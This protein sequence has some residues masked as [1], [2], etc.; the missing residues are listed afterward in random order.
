MQKTMERI[1]GMS[2]AE[3]VTAFKAC[4]GSSKYAAVSRRLSPA[5]SLRPE[6]GLSRKL[7]N[8]GRCV[9][10]RCLS[11]T[12]CAPASPR[13][14][15]MAAA[16]PFSSPGDLKAK[17]DKVWATCGR[18]AS[19]YLRARAHTFLPHISAQHRWASWRN[20]AHNCKITRA[21][22]VTNERR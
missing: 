9:R 1:N 2:H 16:M 13:E 15:G 18:E 20:R 7:F 14:Q 6:P 22:R 21:S 17:S 11:S 3:A 12:L 10:A 8:A 19:F 4:C 5:L